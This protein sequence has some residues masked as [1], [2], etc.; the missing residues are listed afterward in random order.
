MIAATEKPKPISVKARKA[1]AR[2]VQNTVRDD[3]RAMYFLSEHD[4]R[5]TPMGITGPDLQLSDEA[6]KHFPFAVECKCQN[7]LNIW[8][9]LEQAASHAKLDS[10][11]PTP[12]LVFKRDRSEIYVALKW[13]D[14]KKL[15]TNRK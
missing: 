8:Q 6:R 13:S 15:I 3:V 12:L 4:V 9:G 11:N 5:G 2:G 1:K 14:F 7:A 10:T